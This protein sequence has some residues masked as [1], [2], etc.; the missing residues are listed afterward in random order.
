MLIQHLLTERL[1]RNLFQ[2]P[3]FIRKNIIAAQVEKVI[4]ALANGSFSRA[5]FLKNLD[6]T[7]RLSSAK[8]PT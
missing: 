5:G 4:D 7:T 6:R 2:N 8:A 1:M 3:E